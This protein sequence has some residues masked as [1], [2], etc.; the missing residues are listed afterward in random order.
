MNT[1]C[2]IPLVEQ[3]MQNLDPKDAEAKLSAP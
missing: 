1:D 2:K 3:E